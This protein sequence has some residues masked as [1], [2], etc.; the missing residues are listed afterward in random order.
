MKLFLLNRPDLTESGT[1][2]HCVVAAAD[3]ASARLFHPGGIDYLPEDPNNHRWIA[4]WLPVDEIVV[5]YIG[6]T[7]MDEGV[8]CSQLNWGIEGY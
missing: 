7:W 3:E 6:E 5:T 1:Y 2:S 4:A 8:I